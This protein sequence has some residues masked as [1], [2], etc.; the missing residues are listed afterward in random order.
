MSR[1]IYNGKSWSYLPISELKIDDS[2]F[3]REDA[4]SREAVR[5]AAKSAGKKVKMLSGPY[6]GYFTVWIPEPPETEQRR[7]YIRRTATE[8][9]LA[10]RRA[11]RRAWHRAQ[12]EPVDV[13]A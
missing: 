9:Q 7:Q 8:I 4:I 2:L 3:V 1:V 13:F 5:K 12:S 11:E 6:T 10:K